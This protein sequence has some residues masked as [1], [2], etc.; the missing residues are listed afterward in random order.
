MMGSMPRVLV[1][2]TTAL[3][4]VSW[5]AS[6]SRADAESSPL[7]LDSP[8]RKQPPPAPAEPTFALPPIHAAVL[9]NGVR[10]L[11]VERHDLPIVS[12]R[13]GAL[14]GV[15]D[16]PPGVAFLA[17]RALFDGTPARNAANIAGSLRRLGAVTQY[18]VSYD[19]VWLESEVLS[20]RLGDVL[21]I[22]AE[23]FQWSQ[24]P[25]GDFES[26]R[27]REVARVMAD[28]GDPNALIR[29]AID[30]ALYPPPHPYREPLSGDKNALGAVT[31]EQV[32]SFYQTQV[33]PDTT[34]VVIAGDVDRFKAE[35]LVRTAFGRWT[36]HALP[37]WSIPEPNTSPSAPRVVLVDRWG[38]T[39]ATVKVAQVGVSRSCPDRT[40]LQVLTAILGARSGRLSKELR[41]TRGSTYGARASLELGRGS[42]PFVLSTSVAPEKVGEAV[43]FMLGEVRRITAQPVTLDELAYGKGTVQGALPFQFA[44]LRGTVQALA[45]MV[46][47]ERPIEDYAT[48]SN[49]LA[50][51]TPEV[52]L[53]VAKQ[54]LKPD[55]LRVF[56]VARAPTVKAQLQT[57]GMGRVLVVEA[58]HADDMPVGI[59]VE[60]P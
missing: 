37:R 22:L 5:P 38:G 47:S 15:A 11:V 58:S 49:K 41:E 44:S 2:A 60:S 56:V 42:R 21:P 28:A 4:F 52:L 13:V 31:R 36:G 57:L 18:G 20:S 48:L 30:S 25:A 59:P 26:G 24:V 7:A 9:D 32:V 23:M 33:Q 34:V 53:R 46:V 16:A 39:Q 54:Y 12:L 51:L 45:D 10:L 35:N 6:A 14:R 8:A 19:A 29:S 55:E 17:A 1:V 50:L 27:A 3:A 43:S 40:A